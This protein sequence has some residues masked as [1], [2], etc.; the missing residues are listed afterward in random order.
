[1]EYKSKIKSRLYLYKEIKK[2]ESFINKG[3]DINKIKKLS[4]GEKFCN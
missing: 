4:L 3:I 1:M 2:A